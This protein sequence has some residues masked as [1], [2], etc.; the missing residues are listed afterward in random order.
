M[1]ALSP[2]RP[3]LLLNLQAL[4]CIANACSARA[5][6]APSAWLPRA[7]AAAGLASEAPSSS[8]GVSYAA[9]PVGESGEIRDIPWDPVRDSQDSYDHYQDAGSKKHNGNP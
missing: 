7:M 8:H 4:S 1:C 6:S 2:R 3:V 9:E 5:N